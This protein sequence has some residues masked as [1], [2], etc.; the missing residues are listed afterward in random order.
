MY[1]FLLCVSARS[2][3]IKVSYGT[4][5]SYKEVRIRPGPTRASDFQQ[6][7]FSSKKSKARS[8]YLFANETNHLTHMSIWQ[9]TA[10]RPSL[11]VYTG[12]PHFTRFH[13]ARSSLY[14]RFIFLPNGFT[15]CNA[16]HD[17]LTLHCQ[18][19]FV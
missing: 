11:N 8:V 7:R 10:S 2:N 19:T 17:F 12:S 6:I 18:K 9:L 16:L 15:L 4:C 14:T 5:G 3:T 13:F 1:F